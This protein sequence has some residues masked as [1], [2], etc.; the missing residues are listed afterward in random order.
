MKKEAGKDGADPVTQGVAQGCY[1]SARWAECMRKE[2]GRSGMGRKGQRPEGLSRP[3]QIDQRR[4]IG[5]GN[6]GSASCAGLSNHCSGKTHEM[7]QTEE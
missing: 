2:Y 5:A 7:V 1:V 4:L 3:L 6:R